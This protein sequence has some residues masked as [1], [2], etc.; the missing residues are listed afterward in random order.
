MFKIIVMVACIFQATIAIGCETKLNKIIKWDS[1][2]ARLIAFYV[3]TDDDQK[4]DHIYYHRVIEHYSIEG[5]D[6]EII[7]L[8]NKYIFTTEFKKGYTEEEENSTVEIVDYETADKVVTKSIKLKDN[9]PLNE[10]YEIEKDC[11]M[12]YKLNE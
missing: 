7:E 8:E 2:P 6:G 5:H 3:D 9:L 4:A 12:K 10:R 11:M 1:T